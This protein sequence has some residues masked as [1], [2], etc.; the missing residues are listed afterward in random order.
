MMKQFQKNPIM[1]LK[2]SLTMEKDENGQEKAEKI[3]ELFDME[4]AFD[5]Q[6]ETIEQVNS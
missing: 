1:Y 5:Q 2:H 3:L 6:L 4:K